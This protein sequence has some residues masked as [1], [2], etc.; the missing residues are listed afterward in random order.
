MYSKSVCVHAFS[1]I[2][3]KKKVTFSLFYF[4]LLELY[5]HDHLYNVDSELIRFSHVVSAMALVVCVCP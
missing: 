4:S 3:C 1:I 5:L 2:T